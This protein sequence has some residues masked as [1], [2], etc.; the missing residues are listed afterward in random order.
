L[1][2]VECALQQVGLNGELHQ[3]LVELLVTLHFVQAVF[4]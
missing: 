2:A 4:P 1:H 3:R